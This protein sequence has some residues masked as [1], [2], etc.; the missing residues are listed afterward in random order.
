M[1][2]LL[3]ILLSWQTIHEPGWDNTSIMH[4]TASALASSYIVLDMRHNYDAFH[5]WRWHA[6]PY[7]NVGLWKPFLLASG[8]VIGAG[9]IW[10]IFDGFDQERGDGFSWRDLAADAAGAVVG[11][12]LACGIS[13]LLERWSQ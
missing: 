3:T 1:T 9:L 10:E 8:K 5:P 12:A 11:G 2:T 4:F 7:P 13:Y 6:E